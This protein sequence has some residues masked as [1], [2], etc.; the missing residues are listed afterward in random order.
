MGDEDT[1]I[2]IS[3]GSGAVQQGGG[4][5]KKGKPPSMG[6]QIGERAGQIIRL[7]RFLQELARREGLAVVVS[8]QV[9]DRFL[10][11]G[12]VGEDT[13]GSGHGGEGGN[14]AAMQR[15][16]KRRRE[17]AERSWMSSPV[18]R[19]KPVPPSSLNEQAPPFSSPSPGFLHPQVALATTTPKDNQRQQQQQQQAIPQSS[20]NLPLRFATT[21]SQPSK[22]QD[23]LLLDHQLRFFTGWGDTLPPSSSQSSSSSQQ[24]QQQQQQ[25]RNQNL[26]TPCL[27]L[28]WANQ[29]MCRVALIK[30]PAPVVGDWRLGTD[31][32]DTEEGEDATSGTVDIDAST[33]AG[34][35]VLV[36]ASAAI[37]TPFHSAGHGASIILAGLTP[38]QRKLIRD[39]EQNQQEQQQ[40]Q[41]QRLRRSRTAYDD[42]GNPVEN[43]AEGGQGG[44]GG[45]GRGGDGA[46][47]A[48]GSWHRYFKVVFSGYTPK[49]AAAALGKAAGKGFEIWEGGVRSL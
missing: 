7:G 41:Q 37:T 14:V 10:A 13:A 2:E 12:G 35:S 30:E 25:Q 11:G 32:G 20:S 33:E 38:A 49:S 31:R 46:Q 40:Q 6:R 29:L 5:G 47:A 8:N 44:D 39:Q 19:D 3:G 4:L 36:G 22:P 27:G 48:R 34:T 45:S 24:Q 15:G 21:G 28:P 9:A 16:V 26:K 43:T 18:M 42:E 1:G 23:A 17:E